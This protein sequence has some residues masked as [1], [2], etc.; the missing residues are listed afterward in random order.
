MKI[1]S[2]QACVCVRVCEVPKFWCHDPQCLHR[3]SEFRHQQ[4]DSGGLENWGIAV[5]EQRQCP[6]PATHNCLRNWIDTPEQ[7][8]IR[9]G[10]IEAGGSRQKESTSRTLCLP[11]T[12]LFVS[13][14]FIKCTFVIEVGSRG[15][16]HLYKSLP[17][18][19][20]KS[21][22]HQ[23]NHNGAHIHIHAWQRT[24]LRECVVIVLW[25]RCLC[26][27]WIFTCLVSFVFGVNWICDV[28][29]VCSVMCRASA[30]I[31][32]SLVWWETSVERNVS[33]MQ[34]VFQTRQWG[35]I[36]ANER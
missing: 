14:S 28:G 16:L 25:L 1:A 30:Q 5:V 9:K 24:R 33:V 34:C 31:Y 7:V 36:S 13:I 4:R 20:W 2:L 18:H 17:L 29:C 21:K 23:S 3:L 10:K 22:H 35:A 15:M 32:V 26:K 8:R 6:I 27:M 19:G 12:S 11:N